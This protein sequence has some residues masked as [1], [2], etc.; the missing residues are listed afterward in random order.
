[1]RPGLIGGFEGRSLV[2][3]ALVQ[4]EGVREAREIYPKAHPEYQL[5]IMRV[6]RLLVGSSCRHSV[7]QDLRRLCRTDWCQ[8]IKRKPRSC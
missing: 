6:L 5:F 8:R 7:A 2:L 4:R 1:M 3:R